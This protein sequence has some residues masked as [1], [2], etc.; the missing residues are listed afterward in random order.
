MI[1][2][3]KVKGFLGSQIFQVMEELMDMDM[4]MDMDMVMV[5][6]MVTV[7]EGKR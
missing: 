6:D 4:D 5:T 2:I 7:M 1:L 3:L